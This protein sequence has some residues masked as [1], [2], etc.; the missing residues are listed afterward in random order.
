MPEPSLSRQPLRIVADDNMP[1]V[2]A[3]CA[4]LDAEV[5]ILRRPGRTL[6]AAD[7]A[8]ADVLL[9]RSITRV[10]A[11]LLAG[12][13]VRFVG[14]ATI[15]TDHL[16]LPWLEAQ[17][18]AWASAPG[19][20]ARAVGEWVLNVLVQ[21]A[22]EQGVTLAGRTV[23]I[24]GLGHVGRWVARLVRLLGVRVMACDPF[25][26]RSDLPADLAD[27]ELQTLPALLK[28]A[29][30][31]SIH[32]PL[33]RGGEHPTH[34]LLSASELAWLRPDAWLINA[35]R[36]PVIN[37]AALLQ[38][39][40]AR[41]GSSFTAVLDVWEH[42]PVVASPLLQ[43]VRYG[44][45]HIAGHSLEGKWRGTW[46]I[47]EAASCHLGLTLSGSLADI[48]PGDGMPSLSLPSPEPSHATLTPEARLAGVLRSVIA[49]SEDDAR[50]RASLHEDQPAQAFD[51]LRK[52]YPVRREFPA[53]AV[54]MAAE[55][56]L[57]DLFIALGFSC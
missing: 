46:Q 14:T 47:L 32:T 48:V 17:G 42:E 10:D 29:D 38:T 53:H 31:I 50:L 8:D 49:L 24:I 45:P 26:R 30:I 43:R 15:G 4:L 41:A 22:A 51:R 54:T 33:T 40:I 21:L 1:G 55:D 6:S 2:E 20:N 12:S 56:P 28:H 52:Q 23:G 37:N 39:L 27:I 5:D 36:G 18:I 25:L 44:S 57:R 13:R 34:H 11:A 19:C 3:C 9:V 16:D 35:A 7:V